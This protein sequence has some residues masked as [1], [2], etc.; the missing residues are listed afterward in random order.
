MK[1]RFSPEKIIDALKR[2]A[3][4]VKPAELSGSHAAFKGA[5]QKGDC[6]TGCLP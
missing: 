5:V 4:S 2:R 3:A 1:S 6:H